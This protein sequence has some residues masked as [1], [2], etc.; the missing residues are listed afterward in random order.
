VLQDERQYEGWIALEV[1]YP[2]DRVRT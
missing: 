2:T 1:M